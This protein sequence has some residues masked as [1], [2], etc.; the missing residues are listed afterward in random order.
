MTDMK[1]RPK[2][3][4]VWAVAFSVVTTGVAVGQSQPCSRDEAIRAGMAA[5]NLKT[6][7]SVYRFYKQYSHCDDG[8][9][10]E[11]ISDGVAK[12]LANHWDSFGEFVKLASNDKAFEKFVIRHVDETID[13]GRD[14]PKI[15]ENAQLH[16]PLNAARLCKILVLK[17]TLED[18]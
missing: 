6:W 15:H 2:K 9:V 18:K 5:D 4:L 1:S 7:P 13:W 8:S 11:G 3:L 16:C 17:T 12:L 14:A 10:G